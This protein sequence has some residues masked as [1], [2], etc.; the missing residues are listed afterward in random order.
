MV[1]GSV[2]E[3]ACESKRDASGGPRTAF[4]GTLGDVQAVQAF[5]AR[6]GVWPVQ[7]WA[8]T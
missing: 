2:G 7:R 3:N 6:R 5:Y 1:A 8:C 4:V